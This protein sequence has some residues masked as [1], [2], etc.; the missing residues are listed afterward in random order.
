MSLFLSAIGAG[1]GVY[2]SGA[3]IVGSMIKTPRVKSRNLISVIICEA[4]AMYGG[5][6]TFL[7]KHSIVIYPNEE[8]LYNN[9]E[10]YSKVLQNSLI[11]FWI[12]AVVGLCNLVCGVGVGLGGQTVVLADSQSPS[13]FVKLLMIEI[14]ISTIG[15]L[16]LILGMMGLQMVHFPTKA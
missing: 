7:F 11:I 5:V 13:V 10:L 1:L 6:C 16:G 14:F 4:V 2:L 12:G 15:I 3:S 9:P 8:E